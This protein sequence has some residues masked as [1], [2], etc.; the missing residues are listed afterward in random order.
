M[1]TAPLVSWER[2]QAALRR[3]A[4]AETAH[5]AAWAAV[6]LILREYRERIELLF[7]E[8][9]EHPRDPWSGHM[10][11]PGGRR[12]ERDD[13]L[14]HTARR[15][16]HEE[17]GLDLARSGRCIGRLP[18]LRVLRRRELNIAPFAYRLI[19]DV[20]LALSDEVRAV[21]WID[22]AL[23]LEPATH[24][25]IRDPD[26]LSPGEWPCLRI[27]GKIIWGLTLAMW[28]SLAQRFDQQGATDE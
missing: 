28:Q 13:S 15:E 22:T 14:E 3:T 11:F 19:A 26:P 25:M 17:I 5:D 21:H 10:A 20:D 23:L 18:D 8:R 16:T 27:E 1:S 6:A 24:A 2:L 12:E 9:A 4:P 7:I